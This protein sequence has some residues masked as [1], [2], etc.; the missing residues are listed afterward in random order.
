MK[1]KQVNIRIYTTKNCPF[2]RQLKSFLYEHEAPFV[3]VD[4]SN[5]KDKIDECFNI[6]GS[7]ST[8]VIVVNNSEE[9]AII[10][11][12]WNEENKSLIINLL[13]T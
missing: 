2:S 4:I 8:P 11:N 5:D 7:L 3:E 1:N 13:N 12:G 10:L 9:R 6:S